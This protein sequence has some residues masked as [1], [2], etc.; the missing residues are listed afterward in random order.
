MGVALVANHVVNSWQ[1]RAELAIHL[2]LIICTYV[3]NNVGSKAFKKT[4]LQC[5][6]NIT[7]V[8]VAMCS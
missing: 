7:A 5:Y 4:G 1:R 8:C 3:P 2:R 6:S